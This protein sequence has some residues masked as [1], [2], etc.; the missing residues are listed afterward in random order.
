MDRGYQ[1]VTV[2]GKTKLVHRVMVERLTGIKLPVGSVVHHV[3]ENPANNVAGNF[4]VCPNEAY[5][6]LLH[7]RGRALAASGNASHRQCVYC[8]KWDA[9]D[10][11]YI[12]GNVV[13]HRSCHS[14]YNTTSV[15]EKR[16]EARY[17]AI[18]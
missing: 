15:S 10:N 8:R 6:K 3:D 13:R 18:A 1:N 16:K 17:G 9:P 2:E 12:R 4:V 14:E 5:H 7:L 11:L